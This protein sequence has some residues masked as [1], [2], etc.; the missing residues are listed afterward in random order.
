MVAQSTTQAKYMVLTDVANQATWY[1]SFLTELGYDISNP[2]P[3]HGDNKG[4]VNLVLNPVTGRRSKHIPIKHHMICEYVEDGFIEL[5]R[6]PTADML[7]DGFTKPHAY[8]QL[9]D[10]VAGL[11]LI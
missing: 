3:L 11:G 7:A 1:C 4:T 2:I 10:F 9:E 6:T 8:V 5:V